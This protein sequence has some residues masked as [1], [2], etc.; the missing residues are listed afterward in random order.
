MESSGVK[1]DPITGRPEEQVKAERALD[2][3]KSQ[4]ALLQEQANWFQVSKTEA[5][6]KVVG[7][8]QQKLA[9]RIDTLVAA[10]PEAQAFVKI[11]QEM[12]VK[13]GIARAA[14]Q[15][16]HDRYIKKEK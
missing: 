9:T 12:G 3:E 11:L 15:Q 4:E 8:I 10:D 7:L 14:A 1:I 2:A 5:G 16:L 13:E 6:A